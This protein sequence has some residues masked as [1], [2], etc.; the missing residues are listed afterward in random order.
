[1]SLLLAALLFLIGTCVPLLFLSSI[2]WPLAIALNIFLEVFLSAI[3]HTLLPF[4]WIKWLSVVGL[5]SL[6]TFFAFRKMKGKLPTYSRFHWGLL[7]GFVLL[8]L[9]PIMLKQQWAEKPGATTYIRAPFNNDSVRHVILAN[10]I[11]R[12]KASAF[13]P[14]TPLTYQAWWHH[15]AALHLGVLNPET[16]YRPVQGM[17]LMTALLLFGC[18]FQLLHPSYRSHWTLLGILFCIFH[19]DIYHLGLGLWDGRGPTIEV[20]WSSPPFYFRYF[21]SFLV[22][23]SAPQHALFFIL[24]FAFLKSSGFLHWLFLS[25]SLCVSPLLGAFLYPLYRLS[26]LP[27][28]WR[29]FLKQTGLDFLCIGAAILCYPVALRFSLFDIFKRPGNPPV[30]W[31]QLNQEAFMNLPFL[32]IAP[33]GLLGLFCLVLAIQNRHSF[34]KLW[35]WDVLI[36]ALGPVLFHWIA[37]GIEVKRHFAMVAAIAGIHM[38]I[39]L[40]ENTVPRRIL[41]TLFVVGTLLHL[42][43][44]YCYIGKR[45]HVDPSIP[46]AD[47]YAMNKIIQKSYSSVPIFSASDPGKT[48]L[49]YPIAMEVT[50][51]FS[52][53]YH[54]AVHVMLKDEQLKQFTKMTLTQ[55][56]ISYAIELGYPMAIWGP[57][58]EREWG[59]KAKERY[60]HPTHLKAKVGSVEL[61]QIY[62]AYQEPLRKIPKGDFLSR[63]NFYDRHDWKADALSYYYG[64]LESNIEPARAAYYIAMIW[65]KLR[66]PALALGMIER[67]ILENPDWSLSRL[68]AGQGNLFMGEYVKAEMDLRRAIQLQP[69]LMEAYPSLI[70]ALQ[71]QYKF[72]EAEQWKKNYA[73]LQKEPKNEKG[74]P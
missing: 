36:F 48:G 55:E 45:S 24:F 8:T 11:L 67:S 37:T 28:H 33:T 39:R 40:M 21:S 29:K 9:L 58:E 34:K 74:K 5:S 12:G 59:K 1:M 56:P 42:H 13:L 14:N 3:F 65:A 6:L 43:F 31:W 69:T 35:H 2:S 64:S 53:G 44:L 72:E 50:T 23:F 19:T 25:A 57:V 10:G 26:Q 51:S 27:M 62:D 63:G 20:D 47:Y 32:W 49:D 70:D 68:F 22:G 38:A 4:G 61:Y 30:E 46:W 41:G 54:A 7:M 17:V 60:F 52:A 16:A 71:R 18:L 66:Q 15:L 73:A